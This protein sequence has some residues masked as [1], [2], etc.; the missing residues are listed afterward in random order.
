MAGFIGCSAQY[1]SS[2]FELDE[3]VVT[4]ARPSERSL[5]DLAI[6]SRLAPEELRPLSEL[7]PIRDRVTR[8]TGKRGNPGLVR[9]INGETWW[10]F[11]HIRLF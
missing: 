6:E 1:R 8:F 5:M 7:A 3:I 4:L 10:H 9:V 2:L 11:G